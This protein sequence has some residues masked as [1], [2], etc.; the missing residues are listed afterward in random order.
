MAALF[1]VLKCSRTIVYAPLSGRETPGP[2]AQSRL[3]TRFSPVHSDPVFQPLSRNFP[4]LSIA[5]S[6]TDSSAAQQRRMAPSPPLPK[7]E[8][9]AT[10]TRFS[11]NRD[12]AKSNELRRPRCVER[13]RKS[14]PAAHRDP[15]HAPQG[16]IAEA[17]PRAHRPPCRARTPHRRAGRFARP[18]QHGW[19]WETINSFSWVA[20]CTKSGRENRHPIASRSCSSSWKRTAP[21]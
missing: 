11:R 1:R 16:F 19:A 7:A 18:L 9:G 4:N 5:G 21:R 20:F 14:P 8:P 10:A 6:R 17:D 12:R 15:F 2:R 13:D 3:I